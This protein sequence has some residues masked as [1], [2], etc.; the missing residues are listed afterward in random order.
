MEATNLSTTLH[1]M[2]V[3]QSTHGTVRF[4]VEPIISL[5]IQQNYHLGVMVEVQSTQRI[6]PLLS[7]ETLF[8]SII[9]Q[10]VVVQFDHH[11]KLHL[12]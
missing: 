2:L 12:S 5:V 11:I 7:V 6:L 10:G 8:L 4:S 9:Q 3:V 1:A